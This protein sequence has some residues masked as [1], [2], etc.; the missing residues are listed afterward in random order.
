MVAANVS[1]TSI[2]NPKQVLLDTYRCVR[3]PR[4][5]QQLRPVFASF[6]EKSA[7]WRE[8]GLKWSNTKPSST[9]LI[10]FTPSTQNLRLVS[11]PWVRYIRSSGGPNGGNADVAQALRVALAALRR[12]NDP[13]CDYLAGKARQIAILK[14]VA[15][16][17]EGLAHDLCCGIIK[18]RLGSNEG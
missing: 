18:G 7:D 11:C 17:V 3:H 2:E 13:V 4:R 6:K 16:G 9:Q 12:S 8:S 5:N 14:L 10:S 1:S 15:S